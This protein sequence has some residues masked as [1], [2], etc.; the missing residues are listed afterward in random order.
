MRSVARRELLLV[1]LVG[2]LAKMVL[3]GDRRLKL[4][5]DMMMTEHGNGFH[6]WWR[7]RLL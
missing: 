5:F 3:T 7:K 1:V 6:V 2:L 4:Y